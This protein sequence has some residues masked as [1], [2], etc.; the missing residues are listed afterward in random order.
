[1]ADF[2]YSIDRALFVVVNQWL[3]N[4]VFDVIM[5]VLTD[6]N[7]IKPVLVV[8]G[9][10]WVL[11]LVKGGRQ[12][13]MAALLLIP[14]IVISD[15]LSSSVLK[16]LVD[17]I[18]PCAE[19]LDVHL[20]VDCGKGLSF[21]SSHAVNNFAG[22]A[23][24]AHTYPKL[25]WGFY[26]FAGAVAFSR[27]YVGVHYPADVIGGGII[28]WGIGY[29]VIRVSEASVRWWKNRRA[30]SDSAAEKDSLRP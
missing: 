13:R 19:L 8:V 10:L 16:P 25:R 3:Q 23:V 12:G 1:M 27:V 2:L 15:Q 14:T 21:P 30:M 24:L 6:L 4:P 26:I 18:R 5:P 9:L 20:L 7:R 22:A 29:G 11:L 28:G 17:R